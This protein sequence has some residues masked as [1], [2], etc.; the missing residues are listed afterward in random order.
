MASIYST[1]LAEGL[2]AAGTNSD[3]YTAP[4]NTV[5]VVR[6]VILYVVAAGAAQAI[7]AHKAVSYLACL[8]TTAAFQGETF[9]MRAVLAPG[10]ILNMTATGI[11]FSYHVSGYLL[12]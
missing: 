6:C 9:D 5:V 2:Q 12:S 3:I 11:E 10:D 4:A 1:K 7:L 8:T